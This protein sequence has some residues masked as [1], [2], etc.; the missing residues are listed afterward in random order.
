MRSIIAGSLTALALCGPAFAGPIV[1]GSVADWGITVGDGNSSDFSS[2]AVANVIK[3]YTALED[4]NDLAGDSGALGPHFGGQ[5]Y[6]VEFMGVAIDSSRLYIAVVT[7]QRPDNGFARFSPGDIRIVANNGAVYGIEVGGGAGGVAGGLLTE[8]GGAAGSTYSLNGNG[9]TI[10]Y[11]DSLRTVGSIWKDP[12][13]LLDPIASEAEVQMANAGGTQVGMA[14]FAYTRNADPTTQHS[15][16]ELSIDRGI[17]VGASELDI[18]WAPSCNND[19][20]EVQD[21]LPARVPEPG[22]LG[23]L[24]AGLLALRWVRRRR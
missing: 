16:I 18:Y 5:N 6:D 24:A 14:D 10:G 19:V 22:T 13:W 17:F 2:P 7:G 9:F 15:V 3:L 21:D 20:L 1:D 12:T 23:T 8:G 11:A 4:N